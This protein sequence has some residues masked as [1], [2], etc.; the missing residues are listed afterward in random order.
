MDNTIYNSLSE[1]A[2]IALNDVVNEYKDYILEEAFDYSK[3]KNKNYTVWVNDIIEAKTRVDKNTSELYFKNRLNKKKRIYLTTF[4]A[5]VIYAFLGFFI[6]FINTKGIKFDDTNGFAILLGFIGLITSLFSLVFFIFSNKMITS[7]V[8]R[9]SFQYNYTEKYFIVVKLWNQ[10]EQMG[11]KLM[12]LDNDDINNIS[13]VIDY[14]Y[15]NSKPNDAIK[16]KEILLMRNNIVHNPNIKLSNAKIEEIIAMEYSIIEELD[17]L[18]VQ[19]QKNK[20]KMFNKN[21]AANLN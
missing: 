4:L 2:K 21:Q 3:T 17:I 12:Y 5:G 13:S 9:F 19:K 14:L 10:I 15:Q 1:S 18:Y 7:N 11:R 8:D 16:I 6:Y 20:N